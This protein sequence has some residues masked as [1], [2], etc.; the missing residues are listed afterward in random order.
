MYLRILI[1]GTYLQHS[2][3]E[4]TYHVQG[5]TAL[6]LPTVY[7]KIPRRLAGFVFLPI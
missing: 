1:C 2:T 5:P 4:H 7:L 3:L 6:P